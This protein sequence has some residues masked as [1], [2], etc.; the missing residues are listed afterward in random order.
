MA[1]KQG[2]GGKVMVGASTAAFVESWDMTIEDEVLETTGLGSSSFSGIGRGLPKTSF[3]ITWRALDLSDTAT[4]AFL[5]AVQ[6]NATGVTLLL[7][8]SASK[9][10]TSAASSAFITSMT[11]T[12]S[13]NGAVTGSASGVVSGVMT[14][15]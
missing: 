11:H 3:N 10:Y 1:A 2:R 9:Y 12:T 13:I 7:Y 8:E 6:A 4:L 14:Y 5:T 15:T